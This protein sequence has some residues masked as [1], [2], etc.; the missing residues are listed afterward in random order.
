MRAHPADI[1]AMSMRLDQLD[2]T[3]QRYL[4]HCLAA[5]MSFHDWEGLLDDL[6]EAESGGKPKWYEEARKP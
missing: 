3:G 2:E 1:A 5:R 4:L 6:E